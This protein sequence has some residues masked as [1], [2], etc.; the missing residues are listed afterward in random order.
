MRISYTYTSLPPHAR[1]TI[2]SGLLFHE[3]LRTTWDHWG[4]INYGLLFLVQARGHRGKRG[5]VNTRGRHWAKET[6]VSPPNTTTRETNLIVPG[7]TET[8]DFA[9][10][11]PAV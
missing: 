11:V 7:P 1:S 5:G 2:S 4:D 3:P 6:T 9:D 8:H 10:L